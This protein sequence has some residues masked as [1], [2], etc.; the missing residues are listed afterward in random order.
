MLNFF[1][2]KDYSVDVIADRL[3]VNVK[4]INKFI[5]N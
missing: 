1:L 2:D 5:D 3:S 4:T